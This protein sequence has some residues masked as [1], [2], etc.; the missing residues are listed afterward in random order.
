MKCGIGNS[1]LIIGPGAMGLLF[2]ARLER[3]GM[4]IG[5][6]DHRPERAQRLQH[7]TLKEAGPAESQSHVL[8]RADP[9]MVAEYSHV[10]VCVKAQATGAVAQAIAPYIHKKTR[11]LSL[12]NGL[13]HQEALSVLP[14][15]HHIRAGI[16]SYGAYLVDEKTV[17]AAGDG[18]IQIGGAAEDAVCLDWKRRL[19][20]AG[21]RVELHND[22]TQMLW[23]KLIL[24]ASINPV[25]ALFGLCNGALPQ[26]S[27][28]WHMACALLQESVAV[29]NTAGI[30][31]DTVVALQD[32]LRAVCEAT[33]ENRSSML[34][35]FQAGKPTEVAFMNGIIAK[36]GRRNGIPTPHHD[37]ILLQLLGQ[38]ST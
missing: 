3:A 32:T 5:I 28:A 21:F 1:V 19:E 14:C 23:K 25:T 20:Q 35:D 17:Q 9:R 31:I 15:Q 6:L 22:I 7:I 11:V 13:G 10:L 18:V 4:R 30:M 37:A 27:E 34:V 16:T 33:R 2:A 38:K 26:T 8:C 24:N 12:Q 29:A 36:E